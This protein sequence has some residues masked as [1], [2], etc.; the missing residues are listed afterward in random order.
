MAIAL[1]NPRFDAPL[2]Y[3]TAWTTTPIDYNVLENSEGYSGANGSGH[4]CCAVRAGGAGTLVLTDVDGNA[5]T[6]PIGSQ[7][8]LLLQ[9]Q[10]IGA[11]STATNVVVF[12]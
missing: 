6:V 2:R 7:E 10:S 8:T 1:Q 3:R 11:A 9:A 12:W 5:Q 4:M